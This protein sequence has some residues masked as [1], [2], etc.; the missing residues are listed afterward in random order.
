M[1]KLILAL[2]LGAA[3][4]HAQIPNPPTYFSAPLGLSSNAP[5]QNSG[6]LIFSSDANRTMVYPEMTAAVIKVT[7]SVSL[8]ATRNLVAPL[9]LGFNFVIENATTGGQSIQIIGTTGTGVTIANGAA[10]H[11]VSDGTNYVNAGGGS[12]GSM[13]WPSTPG[14]TVCAGTPCAAWGSSLTAPSGTIVGTTDT[15]TLTAKTLD[16]VTPTTMGYVDPTSSIQ[17]QL[18]A[19]APLASPALTGTPTAPTAA[20]GTNT[21]QVATTAFVLANA[22]SS[23][24]LTTKGDL[25]GYSTTN[26]RIGVG[27]DGQALIA[28]STQ[29]TGLRYG[30]PAVTAS[31]FVPAAVCNNAVPTSAAMSVY[32]NNAPTGVC[33]NSAQSTAAGLA[34]AL[35]PSAN[36]YAQGVISFPAYWTHTDAI[37]TLWADTA[38]SG[39]V[40]FKIQTACLANGQTPGSESWTSGVAVATTVPGTVNNYV[41]SSNFASVG[42]PGSGTCPSNP[43]VGGELEFR[44]FLSA[45]SASG[46]NAI[47]QGITF[48]TT[49]SQ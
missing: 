39:T 7:S 38:T 16:G 27:S 22:G 5:F 44:I 46:G 41:I 10:A 31:Q 15:Q 13:E 14:I 42:V 34:F 40:T 24:P 45:N 3:I 18:N 47:V 1:K 19:K 26:A 25:Y 37:V 33:G 21:V 20:P 17:T 23:S 12:G 11:V 2:L 6:T 49:R 30:T 29:A 35:S 8:T 4:S 48:N 32:D 28:D 36:Q 9:A 43:T